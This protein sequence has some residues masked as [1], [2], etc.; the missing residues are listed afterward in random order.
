MVEQLIS[1]SICGLAHMIIY[2]LFHSYIT[3]IFSERYYPHF[4]DKEFMRLRDRAGTVAKPTDIGNSKSLKNM[5][6][7]LL[8]FLLYQP[9][10]QRNI[11]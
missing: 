5:S 10:K 8:L 2:A 11:L 6:L 3:Q 7:R 9:E 4:I 1:S